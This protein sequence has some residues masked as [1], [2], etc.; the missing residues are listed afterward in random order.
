[1]Y[2]SLTWGFAGDDPEGFWSAEVMLSSSNNLL[3]ASTRAD[4]KSDW[5]GY[6]SGFA[7]EED[8]SIQERVFHVPTSSVGGTTHQTMPAPFSDEWMAFSEY[9][10]GYVEIWRVQNGTDGMTA[11]PVAKVEI[12][13]G[14]CCAVS[15]WYD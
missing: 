13:D 7:L 10:F 3:W 2:L 11:G 4:N 1:M 14:G 6:V 8:G 15:L 12:G 5:V 9:P